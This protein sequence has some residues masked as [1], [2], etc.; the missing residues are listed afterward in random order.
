MGVYDT[1]KHVD[2]IKVQK[3]SIS[4]ENFGLNGKGDGYSWN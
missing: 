2:G 1:V 3:V 4:E